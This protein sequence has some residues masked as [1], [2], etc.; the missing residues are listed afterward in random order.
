MHPLKELFQ[1]SLMGW[2]SG[3][4]VSGA[5]HSRENGDPGQSSNDTAR[6]HRLFIR[7]GKTQVEVRLFFDIANS[8]IR[9][10]R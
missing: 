4:R 9:A 10:I 3:V 8:I 7:H 5:G 2:G 1:Q 6:P